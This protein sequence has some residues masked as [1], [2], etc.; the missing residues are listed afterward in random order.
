M[1][2]R[3][4]IDADQLVY[5]VGYASEGEPV[6]DAY[7][8]MDA[9][10]GKIKDECQAKVVD[11]YIGGKGNFRNVIAVTEEYKGNRD[12]KKPTHYEALREFLFEMYDAHRVDGMETDDKVSIELFNN[13]TGDPAMDTV[14][15]SSIDKD[16][17]NTPGWHHNPKS[18]SLDYYTNEQSLRHFYYQMLAGD[19]V[20]NIPGI[21]EL[22]PELFTQYGLRKT[23]SYRIGDKTAKTLLGKTITA[24]EAKRLVYFLYYAQHGDWDYMIE[25]GRLLWMTRTLTEGQPDLWMPDTVIQIEVE[26]HVKHS[27]FPY[28]RPDWA[29]DSG[30]DG[31]WSDDSDKLGITPHRLSA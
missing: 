11:I 29:S 9:A 31:G 25:Q 27:R 10:I 21:I 6:E 16:L 18:G 15:L 14:I 19:R 8:G 2:D 28:S 26:D 22:A 4:L 24:G 3:L 5:S 13:Y 12:D 30:M 1:F 17:K 7:K 23:K 20:D